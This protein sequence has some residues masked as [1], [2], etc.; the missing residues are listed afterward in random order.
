M[1]SF[2]VLPADVAGGQLD[3][4]FLVCPV[5]LETDRQN[6]HYN[7]NV[8]EKKNIHS[9]TKIS[10]LVEFLVFQII[11]LL[12]AFGVCRNISDFG[13]LEGH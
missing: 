4:V 13:G 11:S 5:S 1:C 10:E 2:F 7:L 8:C 12:F 6:I 9:K 3:Q